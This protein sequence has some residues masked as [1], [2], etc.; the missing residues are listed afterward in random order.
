MV[1]MNRFVGVMIFVTTTVV[2]APRAELWD[3]WTP[4]DPDSR[5]Q[6]DHGA[7]GR[8]LDAYLISDHPSGVARF[9]YSEVTAAD[10]AL[11]DTYIATLE[12][13]PVS[14]LDRDRQLAYWI[15][16][17]NAATVQLVLDHYPVDSIRDIAPPGGDGPWGSALWTVEGQAVTLD[18]IEHRILRPI[19]QDPRIHYVVNCASIGCPNLLPEP[20]DAA[21]WPKQFDAA[22][23]AYINHPRGVTVGRR[24]STISSIYRWFVADFGGDEAGVTD[25]LSQYLP[26]EVAQRIALQ[27]G[28]FRYEY[29]WAL[30][31]P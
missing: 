17:Y 23:A 11:L 14:S 12:A 3:R 28:S 2:A 1:S 19:W 27:S 9:R 6:V 31:A 16:L 30:N 29:D 25:H 18:E 21:T 7:W 13:T 5:L 26:P 10:R 15:N 22:A 20:I 8:I 4:H 24:R